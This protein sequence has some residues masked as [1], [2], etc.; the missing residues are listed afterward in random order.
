MYF[1]ILALFVAMQSRRAAPACWTNVETRVTYGS[2]DQL[3]DLQ[4]RV[5]ST[6]CHFIALAWTTKA[7]PTEQS[8]L[9]W[10]AKQQLLFRIHVEKGHAR[11]EKWTG[12]TREGILADDPSDGS[13]SPL[14]R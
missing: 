4:R 13:T 9:L 14:T 7:I 10:E 2:S 5:K 8:L 12:A 1:L 3:R 11:W 6:S